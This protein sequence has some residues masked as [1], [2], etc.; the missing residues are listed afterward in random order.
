MLVLS[1]NIAATGN[2]SLKN[3]YFCRQIISY[4]RK[5]GQIAENIQGTAW[6]IC[7]IRRVVD[8][9]IPASDDFLAGKQCHPLGRRKN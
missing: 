1:I 6:R 4:F 5:S 7:K 2:K 9:N 8:I 3:S